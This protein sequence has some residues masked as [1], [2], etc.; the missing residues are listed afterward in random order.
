MQSLQTSLFVEFLC[1]ALSSEGR[2]EAAEGQLIRVAVL[3]AE[4][5]DPQG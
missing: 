2:R 4:S 5:L 3:G 1:R